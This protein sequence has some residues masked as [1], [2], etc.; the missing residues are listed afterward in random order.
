MINPWN[1]FYSH[2]SNQIAITFRCAGAN[3]VPAVPILLVLP[4][5]ALLAFLGFF[6]SYGRQVGT[7]TT[8]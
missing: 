1:P 2:I 4:V 3:T 7:A 6:A 8:A 5:V